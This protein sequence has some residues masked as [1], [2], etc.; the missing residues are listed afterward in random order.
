MDRNANKLRNTLLHLPTID[1]KTLKHGGLLA[2]LV[3]V[4]S[5]LYHPL[6]QQAMASLYPAFIQVTHLITWTYHY[7]SDAYLLAWACSVWLENLWNGKAFNCLQRCFFS[8][9]FL[10]S[11]F[12][13][14]FIIF[15]AFYIAWDAGFGV[16][17]GFF[18]IVSLV[19]ESTWS[20][21]LV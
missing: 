15:Q 9:N 3:S 1:V 19:S 2:H 13:P 5:T 17:S 14:C 16:F 7:Q 6:L 18:S 21:D 12:W 4:Y 10:N 8:W 20:C 11:F